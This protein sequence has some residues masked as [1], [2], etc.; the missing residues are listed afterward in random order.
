M[1]EKFTKTL[2][3]NNLHLSNLDPPFREN[4]AYFL[5]AERLGDNLNSRCFQSEKY[6][7][8]SG[9]IVILEKSLP[10]DLSSYFKHNQGEVDRP[11][12]LNLIDLLYELIGYSPRSEK[13]PVEWLNDK[14]IEELKKTHKYVSENE[15]GESLTK[16]IR[17][18][19]MRDFWLRARSCT[20][21]A[22][23]IPKQHTGIKLLDLLSVCSGYSNF[24]DFLAIEFGPYY[25][26]EYDLLLKMLLDSKQEINPPAKKSSLVPKKKL[27]KATST[28]IA[29][30]EISSETYGLAEEKKPHHRFGI[31]FILTR[32]FTV[33]P[34]ILLLAS[35]YYM[36]STNSAEVF[37]VA[38]VTT[39]YVSFESAEAA[40][41]RSQENLLFGSIAPF[42]IRNAMYSLD[43]PFPDTLPS[44]LLIKPLKRDKVG[45]EYMNLPKMVRVT[46]NIPTVDDFFIKLSNQEGVFGYVGLKNTLVFSEDGQDS[47]VFESTSRQAGINFQSFGNDAIEVSFFALPE[48]K[49]PPLYV[50]SISFGEHK[51]GQISYGIESAQIKID[52]PNKIITLSPEDLLTLEFENPMKVVAENRNGMIAL[53]ISGMVKSLHA[54]PEI[55]GKSD[56]NNQIPKLYE[57]YFE[58]TEMYFAAIGFSLFAFFWLA[59]KIE[60]KK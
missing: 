3:S 16:E 20:V 32:I 21:L 7:Q 8:N 40:S 37:I 6:V 28:A 11:S 25:N 18:E 45:I 39:K 27:E 35:G 41:L 12:C 59:F 2:I 14:A 22:G 38:D 51:L 24:R 44:E 36:F 29:K 56:S 34:I 50:S 58:S 26:P 49:L 53:Q 52:K 31:V 19:V 55:F 17:W 30:K 47:A 23:S 54:G 48:F 4:F 15:R 9:K 1:V 42:S 33:I 46:M 60:G 5:L 13:T 10:R 43:N 57:K